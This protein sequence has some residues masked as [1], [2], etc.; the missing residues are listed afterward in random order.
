MAVTTHSAILADMRLPDTGFILNPNAA[1][2]NPIVIKR[3][4]AQQQL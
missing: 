4:R 1:E 2:K 3:K